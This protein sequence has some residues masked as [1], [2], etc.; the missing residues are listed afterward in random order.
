MRGRDAPN[1]SGGAM[2]WSFHYI[3]VEDAVLL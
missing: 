3:G 2:F 1:D